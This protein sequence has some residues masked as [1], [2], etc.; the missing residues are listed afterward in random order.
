MKKG[1]PK[2][3]F[4]S[5]EERYFSYYVEELKENGYLIASEYQPEPFVLC[6]ESFVETAGKPFKKFPRKV[7]TADWL[8][9]WSPK[10]RDLFFCDIK[11][12]GK[13]AFF[14]TVEHKSWVD[15][16]GMA[17]RAFPNKSD[18]TFVDRQSWIHQ[19]HGVFVQ[20]V[21][22]S[23]NPKSVF[24]LTFT[25]KRVIEEA[26]YRRDYLRADQQFHRM[27]ESKIRFKFKTIEEFTL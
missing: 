14:Y 26:V 1:R 7:Y 17:F 15:V 11:S 18:T 9:Y 3:A 13:T 6:E 16:K 12:N 24:E 22:V 4:A 2:S 27:G 21:L 20:D 8:L 23:L 25:P 10:A 19:R 5:T